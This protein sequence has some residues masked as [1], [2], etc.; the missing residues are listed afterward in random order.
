MAPWQPIWSRK[1]YL[2]FTFNIKHTGCVL[3]IPVIKEA[4]LVSY[5]KEY[6]CFENFASYISSEKLFLE[7]FL[8]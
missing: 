2:H 1:K 8:V 4:I 6:I 5:T 3:Y 7:V